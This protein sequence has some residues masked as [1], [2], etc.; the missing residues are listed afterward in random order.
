[1]E[2]YELIKSV[3]QRLFDEI[4]E[5]G[6][7]KIPESLYEKIE[8]FNFDVKNFKKQI[9]NE[10]YTDYEISDNKWANIKK[11]MT[12]LLSAHGFNEN[13]KEHLFFEDEDRTLYVDN[14]FNIVPAQFKAFSVN[15]K[16]EVE[17][18]EH[19]GFAVTVALKVY[20]YPHE[21][22]DVDIT[23]IDLAKDHMEAVEKLLKHRTEM[24]CENVCT[25]ISEQKIFD[26]I[27]TEDNLNDS[28]S[29]NM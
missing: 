11:E 15:R 20:N 10:T 16:N 27:N 6:H 23:T 25:I 28:D 2:H 13:K 26:T 12:Y 22:D 5:N 14:I 17:Y 3:Q 18:T 8:Q 4:L 19:N 1:M 24:I 9:E 7:T 21:P 29:L